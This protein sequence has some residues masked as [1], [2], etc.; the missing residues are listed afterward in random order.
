[1]LTEVSD[2]WLSLKPRNREAGP[3]LQFS[4]PP[5][6]KDTLGTIRKGLLGQEKAQSRKR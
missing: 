3:R 6:A 5:V 4:S 2:C 1:M